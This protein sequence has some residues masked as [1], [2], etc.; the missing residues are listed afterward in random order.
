MEMGG[1]NRRSLLIGCACCSVGL[2]P[3]GIGVAL[4]ARPFCRF[5]IR[6]GW[7]DEAGQEY[8]TRKAKS[9]DSSGVPQVV[10]RIEEVL[11]FSSPIEIYI[12]KDED[13][14]FA[15]VAGGR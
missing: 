9:D 14:A 3:S 15:T 8:V 10:Q 4:A 5:S 6:D 2:V 11:S 13:N 12:A 7:T 1:V